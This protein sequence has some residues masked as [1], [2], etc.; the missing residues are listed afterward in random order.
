MKGQII[1]EI[2]HTDT[3]YFGQ[4]EGKSCTILVG[5]QAVVGRNYQGELQWLLTVTKQFRLFIS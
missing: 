4:G 2:T 5:S 3:L 1:T